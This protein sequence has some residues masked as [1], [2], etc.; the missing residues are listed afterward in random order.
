MAICT[1]PLRTSDGENTRQTEWGCLGFSKSLASQGLSASHLG[2]L[3]NNNSQGHIG[4][5]ARWISEASGRFKK[6]C[7]EPV[8]GFVQS[9][10]EGKAASIYAHRAYFQ[11]VSTEKWR[12]RRW[13]LFSTAPSSF[14]SGPGSL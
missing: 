6:A 1:N 11:Y 13:R 9:H 3:N 4:P 12:E 7:P 2:V 14:L 10:A 5:Q 8:E